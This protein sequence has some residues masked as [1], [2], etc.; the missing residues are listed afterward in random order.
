MAK[1]NLRNRNGP[2]G[3]MLD[4]EEE[5]EE[6]EEEGGGGGGGEGGGD[7]C[8]RITAD[9]RKE[10]RSPSLEF[11]LDLPNIFQ[12]AH[13]ETSRHRDIQTS[14]HPDIGKYRHTDIQ[15][16]RHPDIQIYRHTVIQRRET[17]S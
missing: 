16:Y 12:D 5:E 17:Y 2:C 4:V 14:R 1:P 10:S 6:E 15:T 8:N 3:L 11:I 13:I 9:S 7:Y